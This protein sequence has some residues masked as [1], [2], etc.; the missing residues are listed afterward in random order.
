MLRFV[1]QSLLA[2]SVLAGAALQAADR[3]NILF[4][5]SD[6]HATQALSAYN[7]KLKL[8]ETPN[9]DRIAKDGMLFNRCLVTNSICGPSRAVIQTGKYSHLN[10]FYMNGN[11]FNGDQQTFPKLLQKAGYQTA[12]VGKWHLETDPQGFDYWQILPGQGAY[13]NPPMIDNGEKVTHQGYTT[14]IITDLS[15][16]WLKNRDSSKPFMLM[17]QQKAP[18]R[19]WEVAPRHLGWD[20]DREYPLPETLFDDYSGRGVAEERQDM[21]IEI[22]M[23]ERDLKLI[24]PKNYTPDQLAAWKAYYEPRNAAFREASLS[25]KELVKWKYQR[26]M[27]DYLGCV[28]AVDENVGRVLDFLDANGLAENT[29]VVYSSD[30]GFYLGEHGWFDKRWIYEESV[31]TPLLAKW[32]GRIAPGTTC[33]KLVSNLDFPETFLEAAGVEVPADMQGHSLVPLMMG[34]SPADWRTSFYYHYYEFPGAH[35]VRKHY[36]VVT[37]RYKL[38]HFYEPDVNYWELID[39]ETDPN[40]MKSVYGDPAYAEAQQELHAELDRLRA[41]LKVPPPDQ[42]PVRAPR[43]AKGKGDA[44]AKAKAKGKAKK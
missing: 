37:D 10:G 13:Y 6:D 29:L 4:I 30:Q 34:E 28:K 38:F 14:D 32:P 5:F 18:H 22:T 7:H 44:K 15:L 11:R 16:E 9:L 25:G 1:F 20:K 26:Y 12:V 43:A 42:D 41:E 33:D 17:C 23:N 2:L 35:S 21:T 8:L 31:T 39:R 36:G 27:H 40:E 3:P 24:E 19:S